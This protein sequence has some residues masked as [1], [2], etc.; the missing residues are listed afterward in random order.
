M[1]GIFALINNVYTFHPSIIHA[2]FMKGVTRGPEKST[3]KYVDD[4]IWLG[5]HRLAINGLDEVSNQPMTI[6]N[7]TLICNGEIYNYKELF[8]MLNVTP[9]TNSDCEIII[10]LYARF[11]LEYTLQ[12]LD[13]V[14]AFVLHDLRDENEPPLIHVARDPYGVRPLYML[15]PTAFTKEKE[16]VVAFASELKVLHRLTN[17]KPS[18][19]VF[20]HVA[21]GSYLTFTKNSQSGYRLWFLVDQAKYHT[22]KFVNELS[23]DNAKLQLY[24]DFYSDIYSDVYSDIY[25]NIYNRLNMAVKKRVVGTSDRKI[26]CLLSG[27]LDSSLIAALV[28]KYYNNNKDC[29]L[30]TYSIG[31]PGSEDLK[32]AELVAKHLGTKHTSIVVSEEDFFNAIPEVIRAIESY[33]T[34]TVRASVGNYLLGKYIK[35]HSDAKVIFN[36]DG[37]DEV[38]GGYLYFKSAPSNV[39]FDRECKRLLSNIYAFDVLR[40]D[41]CISSHGLEPRT[42]FLDRGFVDYYLSLPAAMRNTN[43]VQEKQLLRRAFKVCDPT[44][45]PEVVLWRRKEAFSDG[46]SSLEKSWYQIIG[47]RVTGVSPVSPQCHCSTGDLAPIELQVALKYDT[48]VLPT[49][50]EQ[51]YYRSLYDSFYSDSA[52]IVPYFWMPNYVNAKDCSAR[53]LDLY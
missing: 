37:S 17:G 34:T 1:C 7:I 29:L 24:S 41:K 53:T 2:G 13:G 15:A 31:L 38:T 16:P 28:N 49:T 33:D 47:E 21:P 40:S 51:V 45:L 6:N 18:D 44:L 35:E 36:G 27:G 46:V 39:E 48:G 12:L 3:I 4:D 5:F 8:S 30:E 43:A 25:S 20:S 32:Y 42:P 52:Y 9:S 23:I 50:P 11:G 19:Y 14:F 26:A 22:Y 10:H